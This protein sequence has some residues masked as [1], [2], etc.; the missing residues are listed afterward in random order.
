MRKHISVAL[1]RLKCNMKITGTDFMVTGS[2][3]NGTITI[4]H[5]II[6]TYTSIAMKNNYLITVCFCDCSVPG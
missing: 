6:F 4:S 5:G 1:E 2:G 3:I